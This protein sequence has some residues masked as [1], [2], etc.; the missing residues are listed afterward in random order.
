MVLDGLWDAY[1]MA[2]DEGDHR[3]A[4]RTLVEIA[5]I[6]GVCDVIDT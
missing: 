2:K 5:K 3:S 6:E 4:T 1:H